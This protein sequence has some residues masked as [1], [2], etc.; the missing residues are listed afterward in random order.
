MVTRWNDFGGASRYARE[1]WGAFDTFDALRREMNRLFFDFERGVSGSEN[2]ELS[3]TWPYAFLEDR[4]TELVVRAHLPG[5]DEK[6][7]ELSADEATLRLKGERADSVP[8]GYSVH[9][10]ERSAYRFARSF[11]LPY[12][13][14]AEKVTA[15]LKNGVLT[16]TLP[17][18]KEAQPRQISVR[19]S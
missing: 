3:H 18:A 9:R 7:L 16:V 6:N 2:E 4:G 19:A 11:T 8:E 10:K 13:V 1:P 14:D 12:K 15:E 5:V 17:K